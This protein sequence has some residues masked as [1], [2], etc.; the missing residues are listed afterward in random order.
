[1]SSRRKAKKAAKKAVKSEPPKQPRRNGPLL[2]L[3]VSSGLAG[4]VRV[5]DNPESLP[6]LAKMDPDDPS[7]LLSNARGGGFFHALVVAKAGGEVLLQEPAN[8]SE[9]EAVYV[10]VAETRG[11]SMGH[12]RSAVSACIEAGTLSVGDKVVAV[13]TVREF[14][15]E[16]PPVE[17]TYAL[18]L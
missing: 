2:L 7:K 10:P 14:E 16:P 11:S 6:L 12:I 4:A 13:R 9:T 1:M 5:P 15:I 17:K 8:P 18:S 3:K